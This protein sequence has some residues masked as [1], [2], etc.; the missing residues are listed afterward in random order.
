[1]SKAVTIGK[2]IITKVTEVVPIR[3][4]HTLLMDREEK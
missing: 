1:M 3:F 2:K 4:L